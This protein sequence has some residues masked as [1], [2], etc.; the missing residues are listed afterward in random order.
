MGFRV[1]GSVATRGSRGLVFFFYLRSWL[2]LSESGFLLSLVKEIIDCF[3]E[4]NSVQ[5]LITFGVSEVNVLGD[6]CVC[7]SSEI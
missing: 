5:E 7:Q 4:V 2:C 1:Q 3:K 6:F